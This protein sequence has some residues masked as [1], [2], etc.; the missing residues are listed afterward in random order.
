MVLKRNKFTC[1]INHSEVGKFSMD[2]EKQDDQSSNKNL[3]MYA[4][5]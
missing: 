4:F 3:N 2:K 1:I 5:F